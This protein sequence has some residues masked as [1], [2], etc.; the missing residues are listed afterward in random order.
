MRTEPKSM[1][2]EAPTTD[3]ELWTGMTFP[4]EGE[5]VFPFGLSPLVVK[6]GVGSY[7]EPNVWMLHD[8]T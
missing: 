1:R 8:M 5:Y 7:W 4:N 2:I 3:W 6:D